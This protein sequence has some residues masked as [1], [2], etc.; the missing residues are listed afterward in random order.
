VRS[1]YLASG[2]LAFLITGCGGTSSPSQ[3]NSILVFAAASTKEAVEQ[4]ARD[5]Q[6][7]T[8]TPVEIN[9]GPSSGLAKQIEQGAAADLFLSADEASADYLAK[10]NLIELRRNLLTNRLVVIVPAESQSA[11]QLKELRDLADPKVHRLAMAEPGVPAGEYARQALR[12]VDILEQVQSKIVGGVDVRAT[13][14]FVARG[15]VHAGLVYYT[16]ALGNS[17]V[18]IAFEV[19]PDLHA[20]ILYPLV[21]LHKNHIQEAARR[22]YDYLASEKAAK[23]F[24]AAH[25]GMAR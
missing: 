22:F 10:R 24:R 2:I 25:F 12:Q 23:V 11:P 19:N 8:A 7:E 3:N 13:L 1:L 5:F 20:P 14:Q 18:R 4:I 9:P 17:K 15:E 16:D 21:L 6:A